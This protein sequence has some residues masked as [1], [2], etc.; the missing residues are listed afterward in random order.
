MSAPVWWPA[1]FLD[2]EETRLHCGP[3]VPCV[4]CGR[5]TRR[6]L[7]QYVGVHRGCEEAEEVARL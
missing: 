6:R 2:V 1:F 5:L 3:A 4:K 7:D